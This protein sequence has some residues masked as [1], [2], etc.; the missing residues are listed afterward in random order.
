M[1]QRLREFYLCIDLRSLGLYRIL[2]ALLLVHDWLTRWPFLE[3]FYTSAGIL[4]IEAPLPR[5]GAPFHFSLLDPVTTLTGVRWVFL[6]GLVCYLLL[7]VG[8]RTRWV[9]LLSLLFFASVRTR[10][11]LVTHGGDT[12]LVTL[13]LWTLLLPLG[14]RFSIDA[15]RAALRR[16]VPLHHRA[17][18]ANGPQLSPPS[19]AALGV[20]FQL[21]LIYL[22]TAFSKT[23]V[24]WRDGTALYYTLH[25]D[26]FTTVFG[27]WFA[28]A[29]LPLL[30]ALS[31]GVLG[32][33]FAALPLFLWPVWQPWTR[34]LA[35][36]GL[37]AFHL[38]TF[39]TLTIG[40]FPWVMITSYA[41][42][43]RPEDWRALGR[44]ADRGARSVV[45]FYDDTCGFCHRCCQWLALSDRAARIRFV[46]NSDRSQVPKQISDADLGT[47]VVVQDAGGRP[48]LRSQALAALAR[49]L[50]LPYRLL[51]VLTWPGIRSITDR[52]YDV[53]A[54]NRYRF[55]KWMG[56]PACGVERV[57]D[58]ASAAPAVEP[59]WSPWR[60][61]ARFTIEVIAAFLLVTIAI[62]S[63]NLS[64]GPRLGAHALRTPVATRAAILAFDLVQGWRMFAPDPLRG[65]GWWVADAAGAGGAHAD[66]LTQRPPVWDKP[67]HLGRRY[68]VYWRAWLFNVSQPRYRSY[69]I[70]YARYLSRMAARTSVP[71]PPLESFHLYY[72]QEDTQPPSTPRPWPVQRFLLWGYDARRDAVLP[73]LEE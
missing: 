20:V 54:R 27:Q 58:E 1:P 12:V 10:N 22:A 64:I 60:R 32:F 30:K 37:S 3:A 44:W 62:D 4:P 59:S 53:V 65:D 57:V 24:T 5:V 26:L 70:W 45:A 8:W 14:A 35:I 69:R 9:H 15:A 73:G 56:S 52:I 61:L 41:L 6:L 71:P 51:G 19:L 63:Y 23:G 68:G 33:E 11:P 17:P 55:S 47:S 29:P 50:P 7:L 66:L 48:R 38:G 21:G 25:I 36:L 13:A 40:S 2:L 42:L 31:W 28:S 18:V 16:G 72:M 46:G 39:F 49:A 34:R 67:S 43:L